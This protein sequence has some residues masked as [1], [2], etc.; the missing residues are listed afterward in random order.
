MPVSFFY[1][2]TNSEK[3]FPDG[4]FRDKE[5]EMSRT[6]YSFWVSQLARGKTELEPDRL[7]GPKPGVSFLWKAPLTFLNHCP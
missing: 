5:N 6:A 4:H 1:P 7:T 2:H 3:R